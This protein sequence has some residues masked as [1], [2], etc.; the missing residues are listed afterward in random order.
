MLFVFGHAPF[1]DTLLGPLENR[2]PPPLDIVP[3]SDI[4]WVVVLGGGST[5]DPGLPLTN[6]LS[7]AS[8]IRLV[9][10]IRIHNQLKNSRLQLSGACIFDSELNA[11]AMVSMAS[12]LRVDTRDMVMESISRDTKDQPRLIQKIVREDRFILVT[13]ASHMPRSMTLFQK[14]G[15]QPMPAPMDF[16]IKKR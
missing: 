14:F 12:H 15:M 16:N 7:Q 4:K 2:Y 11:E 5:S 1:S 10:G 8:P 9:E 6:R 3:V 13:S